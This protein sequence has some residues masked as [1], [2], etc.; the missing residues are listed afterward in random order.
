MDARLTPGD[1]LVMALPVRFDE[2][3]TKVVAWGEPSFYFLEYSRVTPYK[4]Y[5]DAEASEPRWRF[6]KEEWEKLYQSGG[7]FSSIGIQLIRE[8]WGSGL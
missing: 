5:H 1:P 8:P 2:K 6:G 3:R 4:S 7:D